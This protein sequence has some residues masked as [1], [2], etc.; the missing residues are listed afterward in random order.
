[1]S[2]Y[3]ENCRKAEGGGGGFYCSWEFISTISF[4]GIMDIQCLDVNRRR[5]DVIILCCSWLD[6]NS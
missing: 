5:R 4:T 1:M 6:S 3:S 2:S